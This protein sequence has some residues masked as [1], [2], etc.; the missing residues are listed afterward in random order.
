MANSIKEIP[1]YAREQKTKQQK[2][3]NLTETAIIQKPNKN[4]KS[5]DKKQTLPACTDCVTHFSISLMGLA[6]LALALGTILYSSP[7]APLAAGGAIK[8]TNHR[9][10]NTS[11][12]QK[13]SQSKPMETIQKE[14]IDTRERT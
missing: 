12:A 11:H 5:T 8:L 2:T 4:I 3:K 9:Q 14:T 13:L 6:G 7:A 10:A 1:Q